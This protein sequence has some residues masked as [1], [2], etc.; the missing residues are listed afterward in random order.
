[1]VELDGW[2]RP[3]H[4]SWA[5]ANADFERNAKVFM[6]PKAPNY[7]AVFERNSIKIKI[8]KLNCISKLEQKLGI[9]RIMTSAH[10][11]VFLANL[12]F[13]PVSVCSL[14]L[15]FHSPN[16]VPF[17]LLIFIGSTVGA[18]WDRLPFNLS[19]TYQ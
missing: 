15:S 8:L 17:F 11:Q 13:C 10:F 19:P 16:H 18:T 5:I 6:D 12:Q 3:L 9:V 14:L 7:G 1:M 2:R 4:F